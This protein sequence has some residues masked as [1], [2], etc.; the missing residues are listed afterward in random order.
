MDIAKLVQNPEDVRRDMGEAMELVREHFRTKYFKRVQK[1]VS[2]QRQRAISN[3]PREVALLAALKEFAP[4]GRQPSYERATEVLL[5]MDSWQHMRQGIAN[6][7]VGIANI[8]R[9]ESIHHDGVYDIDAACER[10]GTSLGERFAEMMVL[11]SIVSML[12]RD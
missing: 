11:M 8:G 4:P 2:A 12:G 7:R 1:A 9:D 6:G 10:E 3:P 5:A